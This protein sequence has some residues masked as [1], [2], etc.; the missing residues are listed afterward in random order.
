[1]AGERLS[2]LWFG[3]GRLQLTGTTKGGPLSVVHPPSPGTEW[4]LACCRWG[5]VSRGDTHLLFATAIRS[6]QAGFLL[7]LFILLFCPRPLRPVDI[8]QV[9]VVCLSVAPSRK[10]KHIVSLSTRRQLLPREG[11]IRRASSVG[12]PSSGGD[13]PPE[14][15]LLVA[16]KNNIAALFACVSATLPRTEV[17]K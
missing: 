14:N 2:Y 13:L 17:P 6:K 1:M 5:M 3:A 10:K 8:G 16:H 9:V 12:E 15:P 7:L 11:N 4:L